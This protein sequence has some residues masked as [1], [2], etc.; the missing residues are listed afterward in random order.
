[1]TFAV[2]YCLQKMASVPLLTCSFCFKAQAIVI[3]MLTVFK[4]RDSL[5]C[6]VLLISTV[7]R[8]LIKGFSSEPWMF[9]LGKKSKVLI[10]HC[11]LIM[12]DVTFL[13][14]NDFIATVC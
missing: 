8:H 14:V 5:I 12:N 9:Y 11:G 1:M 4:A 6:I 2:T 3:P 13:E 10:F 7:V